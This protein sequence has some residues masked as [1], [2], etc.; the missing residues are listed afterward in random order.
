MFVFLNEK[1]CSLALILLVEPW[2]YTSTTPP[3]QPMQR[4]I[5]QKSDEFSLRLRTQL[6]KP[7]RP[8][9]QIFILE[10]FLRSKKI[11]FLQACRAFLPQNYKIYKFSNFP[12]IHKKS[13][14]SKCCRDFLL[15][16]FR[17]ADIFLSQAHKF[18]LNFR[19]IKNY[20][21]FRELIFRQIERN[22]T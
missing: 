10:N 4:L 12:F 17:R 9:I 19:L 1:K 3:P 22:Y 7:F 6:G 8:W 5:H 18:W 14:C 13:L 15:Q 11:K 20:H 2:N 21:A 16:F